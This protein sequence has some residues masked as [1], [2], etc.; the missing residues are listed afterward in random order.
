[1]STSDPIPRTFSLVVHVVLTLCWAALAI[2]WC[3]WNY[4]AL[5]KRAPITRSHKGIKVLTAFLILWAVCALLNMTLLFVSSK[6]LSLLAPAVGLLDVGA[7]IFLI[8]C[9]LYWAL[10]Y[11][12]VRDVDDTTRPTLVR[13]LIVALVVPCV[14]TLAFVGMAALMAGAA[15]GSF[16]SPDTLMILFWLSS[17]GLL[18]TYAVCWVYYIVVF[19]RFTRDTLNQVANSPISFAQQEQFKR[20]FIWMQRSAIVVF[21][22]M[23]L[24]P[25]AIAAAFSKYSWGLALQAAVNP[26]F[27]LQFVAVV[28]WVYWRQP[29]TDQGSDLD[30]SNDMSVNDI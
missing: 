11:G 30:M 5:P 13:A 7:Q 4:I 1:M 20:R 8:V 19:F 15:A 23:F 27:V 9:M 3:W 26:L 28:C 17:V 29:E 10:G 22:G 21:L 24:V 18:I 14:A 25:I 6:A 12:A 16:A 2:V